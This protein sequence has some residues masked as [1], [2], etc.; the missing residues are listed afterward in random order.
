MTA[1]Y[2]MLMGPPGSG[3]GTQ[4]KRLVEALGIP[5]VSSGD[6]FRAM[7]VMD[8]PLAREIQAIMAR[9]ELV[10]DETTIRVVEERLREVDARKGA[11]LEGCPRIVPPA[12]VLYKPEPKSAV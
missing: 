4:A 6:L 2:I 9:G 3:K 5:H 10:P 8:T 1:A 11:F 12:V 7:K